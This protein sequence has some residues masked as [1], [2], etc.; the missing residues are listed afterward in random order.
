MNIYWKV[1]FNKMVSYSKKLNLDVLN[2]T[3]ELS[4]PTPQP[5]EVSLGDIA[6]SFSGGGYRAA[7][8]HLGVL[9]FLNQI[10]LLDQVT[11]LSTVSGGSITG[12]KYVHALSQ[13]PKKQKPTF[14]SDFYESLH[15]F[16]K[17]Q[18]L[19]D[20]WLS[21]LQI[22][23]ATQKTTRTFSQPPS[24]PNLIRAAASIYA[25]PTEQGGLLGGACLGSIKNAQ[26]DFH[27]KEII[28]NTTELHT[29]LGFRF[30][31]GNLL[32]N[33]DIRIVG[34][35]YFKL[36][37]TVVNKIQLADI[38]AASSCF[39]GGFEP[40]LFPH[41]FKWSDA[42]WKDIEGKVKSSLR[43]KEG[44]LNALPLTDG[45]VNDNLGV[46]ALLS[47]DKW[48]YDQF[49]KSANDPNLQ[50]LIN[51]K[52][53]G[54]LI[55]SDTDNI[56]I[57]EDP[58]NKGNRK[59]LYSR[60]KTLESIGLRRI[61]L[62]QIARLIPVIYLI[63]LICAIAL[64]FDMI[65]AFLTKNMV[66]LFLGAWVELLLVLI[67]YL[68]VFLVGAVRSLT[69]MPQ[70]SL[71]S[72]SIN[73]QGDSCPPKWNLNIFQI[74][75]SELQKIFKDWDN[76][77]KTLGD[78]NIADVFNLIGNRLLSFEP[79]FLVFLKNQR[80][81]VYSS[82]YEST[83]YR[84]KAISCFIYDVKKNFQ[85]LQKNYAAGIPARLSFISNI[86]PLMLMAKYADEVTQ[87]PTTLWF[88]RDKS[89][90]QIDNLIACGQ[91]TMCFNLLEHLNRKG[92]EAPLSQY[93]QT[94][95]KVALESWRNFEKDPKFYVGKN[96]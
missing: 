35:K 5:K 27:I 14:F 65:Y 36:S 7:A 83:R 21:Q 73:R 96:R 93:T 52:R 32:G 72:H 4:E 12:A 50:K 58:D 62:R 19:P 39:P 60:P 55:L 57:D 56:G 45:G 22:Q 16:L 33:K 47:A 13:D 70:T 29:G 28:F 89:E 42:D 90:D 77:L 95:Y 94:V 74:I 63:T 82:V 9:D 8:F 15:T 44:S 76:F 68:L 87:I 64:G 10:G 18:G 88:D 25:T 34:N 86:E 85:S 69:A 3:T 51:Q 41:D 6:L 53:I 46:D 1:R 26:S 91:F 17:T 78:L 84:N 75:L 31:V 92:K 71:N 49:K 59:I 20:Y 40:I 48:L 79:L 11:M 38:V 23:K 37:D 24:S 2:E 67:T 54:T 30:R 80:S 61:T 66:F 43:V 81:R